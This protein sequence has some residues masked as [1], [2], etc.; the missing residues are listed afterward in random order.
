MKKFILILLWLVMLPVSASE[1][2]N[3]YSVNYPL[4]YFA[5]RIGAE[6]VNVQFPVPAD[7]DPAFWKPDAKTLEA[8]QK[9]DLV[10][11]NGAGYAKWVNN[12]SLS[13]L[14]TL[15]TSRSFRDAYIQEQAG[16]KHSHGPGDAHS[17]SGTAFTT[18]LDFQQA[19]AQAEAIK[20]RLIRIQPQNKNSFEQNFQS[21]KQDLM[22]LDN[23]LQ[24]LFSNHKEALLASHP[25][26]QY[27]ARRYA[28]D[29]HALMWEPDV[30]PDNSQWHHFQ[31]LA[32]KTAA[33]FMLW[34]AQPVKDTEKRL[35]QEGMGIVVFNPCA[36]L[37]DDG[38][39]LSEMQKNLKALKQAFEIR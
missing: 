4:Q 36:N 6:H 32:K 19:I 30:Y 38:D 12:V 15:N 24:E 13:R 2:L 23:D 18:W 28:I 22:A 33:K 1:G 31:Q 35:A 34:E 37:P 11:L 8:F 14:R 3:I 5:Q 20:N 10:L 17:H 29:L 25:V 26:Y 27:L 39:F 7:V 21:L 9:A 16:M